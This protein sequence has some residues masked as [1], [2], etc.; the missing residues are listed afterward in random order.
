MQLKLRKVILRDSTQ[1]TSLNSERLATKKYIIDCSNSK[2]QKITSSILTLSCELRLH[3]THG[4]SLGKYCLKDRFHLFFQGILHVQNTKE[5]RRIKP[6]VIL[7]YCVVKLCFFNREKQERQGERSNKKNHRLPYFHFI[8][9]T[10]KL[11]IFCN[12]NNSPLVFLSLFQ[13]KSLK[14]VCLIL[15]SP[16]YARMAVGI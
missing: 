16:R 3:L 15:K 9:T 11:M 1:T 12:F 4:K 7:V 8:Q 6:S 10:Q 14:W 2:H 13:D 5:R